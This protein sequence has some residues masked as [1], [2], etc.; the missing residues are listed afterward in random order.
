MGVAWKGLLPASLELPRDVLVMGDVG[1][2]TQ[3]D[4]KEEGELE[5]TMERDR[6]LVKRIEL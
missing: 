4:V 3:E 1:G 5:D 2:E 6:R